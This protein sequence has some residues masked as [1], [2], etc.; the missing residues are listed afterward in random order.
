MTDSVALA[1]AV[2]LELEKQLQTLPRGA[3]IARASIEKQW[4][5]DY[6]PIRLMRCLT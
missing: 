5:D 4:S 2:D 1:D 6:W 3:F